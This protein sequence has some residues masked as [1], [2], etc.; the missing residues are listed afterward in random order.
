M[1]E[2]AG[3]GEIGRF[4]LGANL[5]LKFDSHCE[6]GTATTYT[7]NCTLCHV[8]PHTLKHLFIY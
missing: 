5:Y 7:I 2:I 3:I 6:I 4:C 1:I 8:H